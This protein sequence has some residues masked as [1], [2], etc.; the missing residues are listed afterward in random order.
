MREDS[1]L[2]KQET[3]VLFAAKEKQCRA[4]ARKTVPSLI[5]C[6]LQSILERAGKS[7]AAEV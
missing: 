4:A 6:C 7:D 2:K 5:S 1:G 3:G